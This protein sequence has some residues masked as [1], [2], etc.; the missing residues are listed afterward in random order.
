MTQRVETNGEVLKR[1]LS[2]KWVPLKK[3]FF[4]NL[5]LRV[6]R[7][8]WQINWKKLSSNIAS[9]RPFSFFY[10]ACGWCFCCCCCCR[11]CPPCPACPAEFSPRELFCLQLFSGLPGNKTKCSQSVSQSVSSLAA[12][13]PITN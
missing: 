3:F 1:N 13:Q 9:S 10:E 6:K 4:L 11:P 12:N 7:K 5:V 2:R 8:N